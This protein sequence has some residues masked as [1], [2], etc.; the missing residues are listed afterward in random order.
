[1]GERGG[2]TKVLPLGGVRVAASKRRAAPARLEPGAADLERPAASRPTRPDAKAG[3]ASPS[4][5]PAS[6]RREA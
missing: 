6:G 2:Q 1:M 4:R 3:T 5:A